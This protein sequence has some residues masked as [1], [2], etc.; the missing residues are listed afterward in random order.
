MGQVVIT[1]GEQDIGFFL[2]KMHLERQD[3]VWLCIKYTNAE[4]MEL[5]SENPDHLHI[6]RCDKRNTGS[7]RDTFQYIGNKIKKIDVLYLLP[8]SEEADDPDIID[9]KRYLSIYDTNTLGIL[10]IL[11]QSAPWVAEG[12]AVISVQEK[13]QITG[14]NDYGYEMANAASAAVLEKWF[15]EYQEKGIHLLR[16]CL[17]N[18][19][20]DLTVSEKSKAETAAAIIKAAEYPGD[21]PNEKI[22]FW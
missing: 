20:P 2:A 6:C 1:G 11:Y 10:R 14:P 19:N 16:I 12:T 9:L 3:H 5:I 8:D 17:E 13:P 21:Y 22:I 7:V 18:R 15:K 4:L